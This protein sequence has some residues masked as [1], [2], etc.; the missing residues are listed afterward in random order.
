MNRDKLSSLNIS[1][2]ILIIVLT[3]LSM[4]LIHFEYGVPRSSEELNI[5]IICLSSIML[6][7]NIIFIF[8]KNENRIIIFKNILY[9]ICTILFILFDGVIWMWFLIGLLYFIIPINGI[10]M[11]LNN[12]NE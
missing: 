1:Y 8:L 12:N 2:Y 3:I 5:T 11:N 7:I 10:K 4:F 6:F 9:D